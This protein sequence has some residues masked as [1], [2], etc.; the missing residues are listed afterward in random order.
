MEALLGRTEAASGKD[1]PK[2][3]AS[4]C[5]PDARTTGPPSRSSYRSSKGARWTNNSPLL[6]LS[7]GESAWG[8]VPL[9]Y[10]RWRSDNPLSHATV[11][12]R[13]PVSVGS[14][15][16]RNNLGAAKRLW[17]ELQSLEK[18]ARNGD[19]SD[20]DIYLRPASS[21]SLL[22]WSALVKGPIDSPYEGGVFRLSIRCGTDYPLSPP[23]ITFE[24]KI[25]HP[26][27]HFDKVG[28]S[29]RFVSNSS[30]F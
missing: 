22:D 8:R 6:P 9:S 24:T 25:F 16:M 13:G 11:P 23:T 26:N 29:E 15:K 10:K 14:W 19:T 20:S 17:K 27:I 18:S 5:P 3:E 21:S 12:P 2:Q 1:Q 4:Q 28:L 30:Q 7:W